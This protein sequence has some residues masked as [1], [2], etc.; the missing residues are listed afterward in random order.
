M[1]S[2]ANPDLVGDA[3]ARIME[4]ALAWAAST[5][6]RKLSMDEIARGARVGRATLYK[7]FPGRDALLS[8]VIER[9]L[10]RFFAEVRAVTERYSDPE[11]RIVH[12]FAA[13]YRLLRDH[14]A[15]QPLRRQSP[16]LLVPYVITD[17]SYALNL[18]RSFV[19]EMEDDD[20]PE[21]QRHRFAEHFARAYHSLILVPSTVLGLDEPGGAEQYA[22]DF[23]IPVFRHLREKT[24]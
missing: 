23:L 15:V 11:D 10:A 8:A 5:G 7:Y 24:A 9:E 18:G 13:A 14:P 3:R 2:D 12:G 20:F 4:S 1:P 22:R 16:E 19:A 6:L 21:P 17:S